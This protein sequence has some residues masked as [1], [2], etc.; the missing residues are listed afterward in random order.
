MLDRVS[1]ASEQEGEEWAVP[2]LTTNALTGEG[3]DK[4]LETVEA[5]RRWLVESGAV[6]YTHL[7]SPRDS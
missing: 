2:V 1:D 3:V 7:P 6:S 4:L 5:H